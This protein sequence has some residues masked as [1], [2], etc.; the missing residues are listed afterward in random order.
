ME[1]LRDV[2]N[3]DEIDIPENLDCESFIRA[4]IE[5]FLLDQKGQLT[6]EKDRRT[7]AETRVDEL[8][9]GLKETMI[10][11]KEREENFDSLARINKEQTKK[12]WTYKLETVP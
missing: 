1:L 5:K 8:T 9:D 12:V 3:E 10:L 6:K 4:A 7:V 11:F 2:S